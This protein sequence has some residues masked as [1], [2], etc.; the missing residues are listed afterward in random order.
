MR[1]VVYTV[2]GIVLICCVSLNAQEIRNIDLT[3]IS[4]RTE[5]RNPPAPPSHCDS[6]SACAAQGGGGVGVGDG[7]PDWRDPHALGVYLE[8]VCPTEINPAQPFEAEFKVLNT[9]LAPIEIP[10]FPHL[11]DLQPNDSAPFDY[12]SISL[13]VRVGGT[14]KGPDVVSLAFVELYGSADHEGTMLV[15]RPGEWVRVKTKMKLRL[16]P[17]EPV[18]ARFRGE[19]WLRKNTFRPYPGGS[20]TEVQNLHPNVTPTPWL[21]VHLLRPAK[22]EQQLQSPCAGRSDSCR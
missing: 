8:R 18:D 4:Q 3:A 1:L 7:A 13:V 10:V 16:W 17:L 2:V 21:A 9:G 20:F 14:P 11:S 15:L 6:G 19:F 22:E 12:S 5:L